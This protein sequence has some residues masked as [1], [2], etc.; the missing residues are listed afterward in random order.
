ME[1]LG[2]R[3]QGPGRVYLVGGATALLLGFRNQTID[4]DI[5]LDPEPKAVFESIA[6]LKEDLDLNVELASPDQF[7][8]PLPG[9]RER[10]RFIKR[11]GPVEFFHYDFYGQAL[12]KVLRGYRTDLSDVRDLI[13]RGYVDLARLEE[14]FRATETEYLRYPAVTFSDLEQKL[15]ALPEDLR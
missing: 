10:S 13:S 3:A 14:L 6:G 9:W 12:S 4:I 11:I 1:G 7:I 2:Q 15:R 8:P 5:K